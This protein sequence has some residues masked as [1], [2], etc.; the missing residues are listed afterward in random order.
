MSQSVLLVG[1]DRTLVA[2]APSS[3]RAHPDVDAETIRAGVAANHAA[4]RRQGFDVDV[5][6]LDYGRSAVFR[7]ALARVAYDYVMIGA[8]VRLDPELTHLFEVLVHTTRELAPSATLV[9]NTGPETSA[10]A[11][12]RW[13]P[14]RTPLVDRATGSADD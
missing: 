10:E 2:D 13:H 7:A 14:T 5:C 8:G 12:G 9:F 3:R 11:V 6:A 1:L 4:L